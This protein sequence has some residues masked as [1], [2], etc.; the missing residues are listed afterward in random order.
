[1]AVEIDALAVIA[2][3]ET[4][5][6]GTGA[7]TGVVALPSVDLHAGV[8]IDIGG[9]LA[10]GFGARTVAAL[11]AVGAQS[12]QLADAM[13]YFAQQAASIDEQSAAMLLRPS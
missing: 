10:G 12:A 9:W 1:M 7:A 11:H 2:V 4:L 3:A 6:A 8:L 13:T 5:H